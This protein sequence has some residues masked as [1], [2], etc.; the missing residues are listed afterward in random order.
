MRVGNRRI[1]IVEMLMLRQVLPANEPSRTVVSV[2][3]EDLPRNVPP[4]SE[5]L[6]NQESG[7]AWLGRFSAQANLRAAYG[8][9]VLRDSRRG[10]P[11]ISP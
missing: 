1:D 5:I 7:V 9:R 4:I 8:L 3:C 11:N 10:K 6:E 2:K